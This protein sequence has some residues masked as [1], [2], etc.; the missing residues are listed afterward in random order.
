[1]DTFKLKDYTIFTKKIGMGA[2]STIYKGYKTNQKNTD[3]FY[4]F[5]KI[6]ILKQ[7]NKDYQREFQLLRTLN[8]KNVIKLH[9]LIIDNK[10]D[11]LY[12]VFDYF[13]KGD[14]YKRIK[15]KSLKEKFAKK[16]MLQIKD[17]LKYLMD[18]NILH[19]DIKPQNILINEQNNIVITDFGLAKYFNSD[20]MIETMCGSPMYMA[21][22]VINRM[23]YTIK[24]DLW[25]LGV[26]MYQMLYGT[27]P[28]KANNIVSLM[29]EIQKNHID[30]TCRTQDISVD[31]RNLLRSLLQK[32]PSNRITWE[33]FFDHAWFKNDDFLNHENKLMEISLS[34]FSFKQ[35]S[36]ESF[37]NA[38]SEYNSYVYKSIQDSD[39]LTK[40]DNLILLSFENSDSESDS[41][42]NSSDEEDIDVYQNVSVKDINNEIESSLISKTISLPINI[43]NKQNQ[44]VLVNKNVS[45]PSNRSNE[46]KSLTESFKQYVNKSLEFV[47]NSYDYLSAS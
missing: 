28:F 25:S 30:F 14:L 36:A 6:D 20:T 23:P 45:L 37:V 32:N 12:L 35:T 44:Y 21:P 13:E 18:N 3:R 24:S 22:E 41:S 4:A 33:E 17:G 19:R 7:K 29:S 39:E 2:F 5:K 38:E 34:N 8:H 11:S 15:G 47:K 40:G 46:K 1:M 43:D 31:C 16:Y 10:N 27:F 42:D 26:L 9:D